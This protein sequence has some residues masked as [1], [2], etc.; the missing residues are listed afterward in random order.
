MAPVLPMPP[1]I[2][3]S[4]F[5]WTCRRNAAFVEHAVSPGRHDVRYQLARRI[6]EYLESGAR[7]S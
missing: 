3:K 5:S 7:N 6:V 2:G 4:L 1:Q